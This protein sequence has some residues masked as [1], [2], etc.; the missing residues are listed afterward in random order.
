MNI[1]FKSETVHWHVNYVKITLEVITYGL[2]EA[3]K[4]DVK[5]VKRKRLTCT[6]ETFGH[7]AKRG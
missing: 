3:Y 4:T 1:H 7:K 2:I 5:A 6:D